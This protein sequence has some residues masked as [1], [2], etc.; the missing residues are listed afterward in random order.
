MLFLFLFSCYVFYS[1]FSL[2]LSQVGLS[3]QWGEKHS[4]GVRQNALKFLLEMWHLVVSWVDGVSF[5]I[6]LWSFLWRNGFGWVRGC[7]SCQEA[8]HLHR[9]CVAL[10]EI[11]LLQLL[12]L[13]SLGADVSSGTAHYA[14][15]KLVYRLLLFMIDVGLSAF[16]YLNVITKKKPKHI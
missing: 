2:L 14:P 16:K 10:K 15:S 13:F 11:L 3:E 7:F 12:A 4:T 9:C 5:Y 6:I 1:A 8:L